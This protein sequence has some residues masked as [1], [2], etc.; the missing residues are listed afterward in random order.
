LSVIETAREVA[1][2]PARRP[3]REGASERREEVVNR[4][5]FRRPTKMVKQGGSGSRRPKEKECGQRKISSASFGPNQPVRE[6]TRRSRKG[7]GPG[8][9]GEMN[10]G[11]PA[12]DLAGPHEEESRWRSGGEGRKP[13]RLPPE[14]GSRELDRRTF[15]KEAFVSKG[16]AEASTGAHEEAE[17][18]KENR[19]PPTK[20]LRANRPDDAAR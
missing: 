14:Y 3:K 10:K 16:G 20:T 4:K 17:K 7:E 6:T 13:S 15:R 18:L 9:G 5:A 12:V 2:K 11:G 19:A 1:K 8:T